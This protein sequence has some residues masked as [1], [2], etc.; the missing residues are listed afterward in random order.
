[1]LRSGLRGG[2]AALDQ[3][4]CRQRPPAPIAVSAAVSS[5][6]GGTVAGDPEHPA[7]RGRL[8]SKGAALARTWM[9]RAD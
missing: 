4:E 7:N 6:T 3:H 8:C 5:S 9:T 1:M 2:R